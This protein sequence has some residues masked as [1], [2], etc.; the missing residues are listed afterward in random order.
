M[1]VVFDIISVVL[2]PVIVI[3]PSDNTSVVLGN[4]ING[5]VP[6]Q[7]STITAK[8]RVGVGSLGNVAANAIT[9]LDTEIA[10]IVFPSTTTSTAGVGGQDPESLSSIKT[11][12]PT[13]RRTQ[14]RAVT[15]EDYKSLVKGFPGV[16]KAHVLT[17]TTS[18][19]V[20]VHYSGLP[21]I[22]NFET[23]DDNTA[24]VLTTDFGASGT[25]VSTYLN[26]HLS[27]RSMLGVTVSQIS[28]TVNLVNVYIGFGRVEVRPGYIQSEV[29]AAITNA[30][31]DLFTWDAVK[32]DQTI[33]ASEVTAAAL[34]VTGVEAGGVTLS[35][36]SANS[37]GTSTA[38]YVITPT[39]SSA[40]YLP[41]LRTVSYAGVTGGIA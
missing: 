10:N 18:G 26:S 37:V 34:A 29:T 3:L 27:A 7:G 20:T 31:R 13:L 41:V 40:I 16:S 4:G 9:S 2:L 36:V 23:R 28:A 8:Y 1:T 12:A 35:N 6:T 14:D 24:L 21:N 38:D 19:V 22:P 25:E 33:R 39:T 17:S 11:H 32:F 15:L 5:L 30:I